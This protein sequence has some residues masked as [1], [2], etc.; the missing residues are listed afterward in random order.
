M[1][2]IEKKNEEKIRIL[3]GM[4]DVRRTILENVKKIPDN[5]Q[6]TPFV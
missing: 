6:D 5:K 2:T 4:E 1:N 3:K